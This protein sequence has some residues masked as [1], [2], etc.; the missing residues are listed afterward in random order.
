MI[1]AYMD[2]KYVTGLRQGD[3]LN[4]RLDQLKDDGIHLTVGKSRKRIVI[5]WTD[6]LR[7]AVG[8]ARQLRRPVRGLY[9]FCNR[10]RQPYTGNCFRSL[11]QRRMRSALK[12]GGLKERFRDHD[13]RAK[14]AS[15]ADREHAK[16]LMAHLDARTTARH[17]RRKPEIVRPLK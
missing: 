17:Y 1:A 6:A 9:L 11:W 5:S 13:I 4:L 14:A 16:E 12:T 8:A 15:D 2:F 7:G 10:K 3:I